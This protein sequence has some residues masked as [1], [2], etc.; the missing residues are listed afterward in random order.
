MTAGREWING[1]SQWESGTGAMNNGLGKEG[2]E[3]NWELRHT[4]TGDS[5]G[6]E[7]FKT[8][9]LSECLQLPSR[10]VAKDSSCRRRTTASG[11]LDTCSLYLISMLWIWGWVPLHFECWSQTSTPSSRRE[12]KRRQSTQSTRQFKTRTMSARA[13]DEVALQLLRDRNLRPS[14]RSAR[15]A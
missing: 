7:V 10:S 15:L 14:K 1:V 2:Q 12:G 4:N 3:T 11:A 9:R 5:N 8:G 13:Q 6:V